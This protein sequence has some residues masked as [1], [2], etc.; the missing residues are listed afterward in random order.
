MGKSG[1]TKAPLDG[2]VVIGLTRGFADPYAT[3]LLG[4]MSAN[5]IKIEDPKGG[6]TT[7]HSACDVVSSLADVAS[8]PQVKCNEMVVEVDHPKIG[9]LIVVGNPL[10][11]GRTPASLGRPAPPLG[12]H[13]HKILKGLGLESEDPEQRMNRRSLEEAQTP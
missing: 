12:G 1:Q 9:P 13:S 10:K 3:T 8:N 11:L 7:R 5:I 6:D 4:G 2:L